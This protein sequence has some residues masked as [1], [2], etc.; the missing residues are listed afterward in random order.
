MPT[1]GARSWRSVAG[2]K[3]RI[4]AFHEA[5]HAV[6]SRV[7]GIEV[8]YVSVISTAADNAGNVPTRSASWLAKHLDASARILATEK[9][10]KVTFAGMAANERAGIK[11][12]ANDEA[13]EQDIRNAQRLASNITKLKPGGQVC[14]TADKLSGEIVADTKAVFERIQYDTADLV[15]EHWPAIERVA[16]YLERH[17]RIHR[18]DLD[19]LIATAR[20]Q[21]HIRDAP[22]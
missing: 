13:L 11:F 22:S 9:D 19:R 15:D 3:R 5:G 7:L 12:T 1:S 8:D 2:T 20:S 4:R 17:G 16:K 6:I 14:D 21:N 18:V 10:L